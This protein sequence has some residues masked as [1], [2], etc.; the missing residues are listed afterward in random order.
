MLA[1]IR[2]TNA[3]RSLTDLF[4]GVWHRSLPTI[5]TR[6]RNE[7]IL[8]LRRDLQQDILKAYTFEPEVLSEEDGS[9]TLALEELELVVNAPTLEEAVSEMV[10]E[11]TVYA[12]DYK[13]RI[14]VFLNAP[15]RRGHFPYILRVWLCDDERKVRSL[16]GI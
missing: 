5:V 11:M 12:A 4:D 16:L 10:K 3:R 6:R 7:E 15:N 13:E 8:L 14:Q 9:I 2:F 1:E